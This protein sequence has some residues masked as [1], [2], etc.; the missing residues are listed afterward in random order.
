MGQKLNQHPNKDSKE[1]FSDRVEDYVRFRPTY[2]EAVVVTL[3]THYGL[4]EQSH[5]VDIGSGTGI[6]AELFLRTGC[7]VT[8]VEPNAEMRAAAEKILARYPKF[9]SVNGSAE[10]TTLP[11]ASADFVLAAQAFHWFDPEPARREWRR[12]LKPGGHACV[13]YNERDS[14]TPFG[15]EYEKF[16]ASL[17]SDYARVNQKK[18]TEKQHHDFLGDFQEYRFPN[19]QKLDFDSLLG[20]LRSSSYAPRLDSPEYPGAVEK[21]RAL[22][23]KH[24]VKGKV[25][26]DYTTELFVARWE[27]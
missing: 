25:T 22:F 21:L 27:K 15:A 13:L 10:A 4:S 14:S 9:R 6:S 24:A 1:R 20:R 3:Q 23:E 7:A 26:M 17:E 5:L 11:S 19:A 16:L 8:G 18:V 12:I 2:P